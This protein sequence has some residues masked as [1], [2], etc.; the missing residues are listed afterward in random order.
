MP[1]AA[2]LR[3]RLGRT[4]CRAPSGR[5]PGGRPACAYLTKSSDTQRGQHAVGAEA[6][7]DLLQLDEAAHQ[8]PGADQQHERDRDLRDDQRVARA[9]TAA[10]DGAVPGILHRRVGAP[11]Q[12]RQQAEQQ[13]GEHRH[14]EGE[15]QHDAV[16]RDFLG[17][18]REARGE[19]DEQVARPASRPAGRARRRRRASS[20][21]S[22]S[23]WR[24]MRP[25]P[26]P[27]ALRSASSRS[28]PITRASAR[29]A[30]FAA[31]SS[32]TK[33][34]TAS[35]TSSVGRACRV[36]SSCTESAVA[37]K[38]VFVRVVGLR[39]IARSVGR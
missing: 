7:V 5:R 34:V 16:D 18:R 13:A 35:S 2:R 24:A 33:P 36:S 20:V 27:S 22:V 31:T 8:Q 11:R 26:A 3:A 37:W 19:G 4:P 29:L 23:S 21:L 30:T 17:A 39:D 12:R 28:R 6:G 1:S 14:A 9:E 38:P 32:S 15:R 10:A 25:R